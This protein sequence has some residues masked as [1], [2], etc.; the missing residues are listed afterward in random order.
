MK[1]KIDLDFLVIGAQKSGTTSL[2]DWLSQHND[3]ILPSIKETHFFSHEERFL[4]GL[5]WYESQFHRKKEACSLKGEI[6]PEY[7]FSTVAL[8]RIKD[9]SD[10]KKF[11]VI[12]RNPLERAYSQYL[13]SVRRGYEKLPFD[14]AL[15][16]ESKRL[17][18][19]GDFSLDHHSYL[20]RSLYSEQIKRYKLNFPDADFMFI[21]FDDLINKNNGAHVYRKI[22]AFIGSM[23]DVNTVD[24]SES[25]NK[26]SVPR[27]IWLR[28]LIYRNGERSLVRKVAS[29]LVSDDIKLKL[30]LFLDK[31][32]QKKPEVSSMQNLK[33]IRIDEKIVSQILIDLDKVE[34]ITGLSLSDWKE[35]ISSDFMRSNQ[36]SSL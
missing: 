17:K 2:H 26:A 24:R 32:N 36:E 19:G 28:D 1:S 27:W 34:D 18:D 4:K 16:F 23:H 5:E 9:L 8:K 11:I 22:V 33:D 31:H 10:V 7:L 14:Q 13:M 29:F 3:V 30:F 25:S 21:K 20:S 35:S 12:L 6:D 15:C